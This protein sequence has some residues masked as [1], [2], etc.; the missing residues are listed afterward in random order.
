MAE[1]ITVDSGT[2]NTRIYLVRDRIIVDNLKYS[3]GTKSGNSLLR[4]TLRNGIDK[5]MKRHKL[6]NEDITRIL[7]SGMITS[8]L[9]LIELPHIT[10]PAGIAELHGAMYETVFEDISEIPF[11]FSR[12]VKT[13]ADD[14]EKNDIMR[15]EET[16]LMGILDGEGVYVLPGSHSKII[17]V[18]KD[19]RITAFK[20]MLTGEMISALSQN[21]ILK[22]AI[23]LNIS[24]ANEEYLLKGFEY[25]DRHGINEA[26]F[27]VR[28]LKN[29][30][31]RNAEEIY[32][33]FMGVILCDEI[34]QVLAYS[35]KRVFIGGKKVIKVCEA[36][37][38]RKISKAETV[39]KSYDAENA[40]V[41]GV[42][43]VYEYRNETV[44][45][46]SLQTGGG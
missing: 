5:L 14:L 31:V 2:T 13:E 18:G 8:E 29:L 42:V 38:L 15:G 22:D 35:P 40:S 1:Y 4:E 17:Q 37:L 20:T 12:G 33:F 9:G 36:L 6:C 34:K 21:T 30:F 19:G 7:T 43:K 3:V 28:I 27:K 26:L 16:E 46:D 25:A 10:A 39:V 32:G 44:S 45:Q 23:D 11:V 41:L 24:K